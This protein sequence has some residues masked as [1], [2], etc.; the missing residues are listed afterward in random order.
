MKIDRGIIDNMYTGLAPE[1]RA[2]LNQAVET[3]V[4]TKERGGRVVAV[5]GSGPNIHEG[6]TTLIAELMHKKIIDGVSTSSAVIGHEMAG[7]LEKV[8]RIDGKTLGF[9]A[10]RLPCDGRFEVSLISDKMLETY[11]R[12]IFIDVPLYRKMRRARGNT[13]IKVAGN[14]AYPT[15]LR[16]ERLARDVLALSRRYGLPFEQ[17]VGYGADPCTMIGAGAQNRIPVLVTVPQLVGSGEVGLCIGD[18]IPISER[19]HSMARV[20]ADADVIIES[21]LALSQEIHD[22]PFER[23]TGHGIWA[24]WE[25]GWTYSLKDKKIIRIDLDPNLEKAWQRERSSGMVSEAVDKGLPKTLSMQIPFR[26]EMSGFARI[27]G[28]LPVVGD[29]GEIWP[30]MAAKAADALG[31]KLDL[32]SYKQ[33]LPAGQKFREWIVRNVRPVD[34]DKMFAAMKN[35]GSGTGRRG[36]AKN[37]VL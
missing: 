20:L 14:M 18:S 35:R 21:A 9:D 17:V 36:A 22:G 3:I 34:K 13:I 16:T 10:D 4:K 28:S 5:V 27:P 25:G 1:T 33:S 31:I 15:G 2:R 6:V 8:K 30:V 29:I 7:A 24:D 32:M 23:F 12:E 11:Q 37:P 19:C 26:M